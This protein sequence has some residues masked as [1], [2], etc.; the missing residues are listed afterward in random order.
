MNWFKCLVYF[1]LAAPLPV[2]LA[3]EKQSVPYFFQY[4]N[5][6]QGWRACNITSVAMV[7]DHYQ[8]SLPEHKYSRT[9]DYLFER[10]GIK[11]NPEELAAIFNILAREANSGVRDMFYENGTI[12]QLREHV[13]TGHPAIVHG[14]F[15]ESGHI[16]VVTG[17]DGDNYIVNDPAGKWNL[18]KFAAGKYNNEVSGKNIKY[19]AKA[20]DHAINDNGTGDDLWLHLFKTK[21]Q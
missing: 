13:K 8:V 16:V 19:P 4:D 11:Q 15:T 21:D 20:F 3:S 1:M 6:Q 5:L 9:P 14:W 18:K 2:V 10:F 7:L 17:F 12:Q